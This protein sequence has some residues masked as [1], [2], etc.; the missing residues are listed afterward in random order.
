MLAEDFA[1][2]ERNVFT[3][4]EF[5][6]VAVGDDGH[7]VPLAFDAASDLGGASSREAESPR[8]SGGGSEA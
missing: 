1:S 5:A 2:G 6:R 7:P 8:A 3:T 4:G